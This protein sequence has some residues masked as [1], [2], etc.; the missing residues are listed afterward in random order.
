MIV[1][2]ESK[3]AIVIRDFLAP[4]ELPEKLESL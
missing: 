3:N 1:H 2:L 4:L